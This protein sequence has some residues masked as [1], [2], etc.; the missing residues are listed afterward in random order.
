MLQGVKLGW[1]PY[2]RWDR[3]RTGGYICTNM[4]NSNKWG[5]CGYYFGC[6]ALLCH[7]YCYQH[8]P[9]NA[10]TPLHA[11]TLAMCLNKNLMG[12]EGSKGF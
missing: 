7:H 11:M 2:A 3:G 9:R 12:R 6:G 4:F 8:H 1:Y 5:P 10:V